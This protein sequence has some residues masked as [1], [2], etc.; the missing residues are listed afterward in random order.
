MFSRVEFS[1]SVLARVDV[2][3]FTT[4]DLDYVSICFVVFLDLDVLSERIINVSEYVC[5]EKSTS[6]DMDLF[7]SIMERLNFLRVYIF[8][9]LSQIITK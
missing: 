2:F 7:K 5:G 1:P 6:Y 9:F 3:D 4:L 8:Y